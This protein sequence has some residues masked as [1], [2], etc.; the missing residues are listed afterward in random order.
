MALVNIVVNMSQMSAMVEGAYG[1]F[2]LLPPAG[3]AE[4]GAGLVVATLVLTTATVAAAVL[5]GYKRVEKIMTALLLV[6]LFCFIVVAI[7]GLLDWQT[8]IALGR[9]LVPSIPPN[10]PVGGHP[11]CIAQR[12]HAGDGHRRARRCR[13]R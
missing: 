11:R 9:G 7:K 1:A 8:W 5:G 10:V 4:G 6:I 2:G 12:P 3:A 13:R